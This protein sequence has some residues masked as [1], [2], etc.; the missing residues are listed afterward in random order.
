MPKKSQLDKAI[1]TLTEEIAD[2]ERAETSRR[3]A[4]QAAVD[5]K[6]GAVD[7]L[8]AMQ[9]KAMRKPRAVPEQIER[10]S[11]ASA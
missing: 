5:A 4:H 1:A 7:T 11:L 6:C 2:M 10:P 3:E 8:R 9:R